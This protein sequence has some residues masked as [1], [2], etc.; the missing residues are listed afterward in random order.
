M[1][2]NILAIFSWGDLLANEGIDDALRRAFIVYML[3]HCPENSDL[4]LTIDAAR[5]DACEIAA[6]ARG[7]SM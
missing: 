6:T 2:A 4:G 3:M 1:T 5:F 7:E